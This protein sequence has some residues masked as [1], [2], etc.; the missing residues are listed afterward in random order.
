M[1]NNYLKYRGRIDL[2]EV[3]NNIE[4]ILQPQKQ[5]LYVY[6]WNSAKGT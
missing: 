4:A 3:S 2:K 6:V 5:S 1:N